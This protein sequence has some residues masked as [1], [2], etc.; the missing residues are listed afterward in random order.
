MYISRSEITLQDEAE[1][2][3]VARIEAANASRRVT[4]GFRWAMLLHSMDDARRFASVSMWLT[5]EQAQN[6][7]DANQAPAPQHGY[8]V[9]TARGSMTPAA[10]AAIVDWQVEGADA[11]RFVN[12][13]N[14]AYHAIEDVFGSRLLQ[15]LDQPTAYT[16]LHVV[17]DPARLAPKVLNAEL[18]DAEG[19]ALRPVAIHRFEVVLLTEA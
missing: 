15:D 14:A 2:D 4:D 17:T 10:A 6:W 16:G 13:W 1:G 7:R 19:L 11:A 12:R 8:D 9:A 18:T 3:L 5:P